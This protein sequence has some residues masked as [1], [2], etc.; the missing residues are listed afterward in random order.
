[1]PSTDTIDDFLRIRCAGKRVAIVGGAHALLDMNVADE[2]DSHD[3]VVRINWHW[4]HLN[5]QSGDQTDKLGRKFDIAWVASF[6]M[7][8]AKLREAA[9]NVDTVLA[10]A[11]EL[12]ESAR[13]LKLCPGTG[14]KNLNQE[15]S[16][17][18]IQVIAT[19]SRRR[20]AESRI[21]PH[22][23]GV[24]RKWRL[25][26][27]LIAAYSIRVKEPAWLTLFGFDFYESN[28]NNNPVHDQTINRSFAEKFVLSQPRVTRRTIDEQ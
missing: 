2:I 7:S 12:P 23:P 9:G 11:I 19:N 17:L 25:N 28:E 21:A 22:F 5:Y 6:A 26:T 16:R 13:P 8:P 14:W 10:P 24:K 3:V 4:P 1:M 20:L 27:G 15:A 18:G